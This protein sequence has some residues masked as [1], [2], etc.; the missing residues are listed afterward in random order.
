MKRLLLL[1]LLLASAL[2]ARAA[3]TAAE[4]AVLDRAADFDK[5]IASGQADR[6]RPFLHGRYIYTE[7]LKDA[8]TAQPKLPRTLEDQLAN[9]LLREVTVGLAP[10][11]VTLVDQTA[12]VTGSYQVI[13]RPG[14]DH[15][16]PLAPRLLLRGFFSQT[17]IT[18]APGNTWLLLSEHRSLHDMQTWA[19][20]L[21]KNDTVPSL[22]VASAPTPP[23]ETTHE[24]RERRAQLAAHRGFLPPTFTDLFR[25]Y[26]P[27]SIGYTVDEGDDSFMDFS[28]SAMFPLL[29]PDNYPANLRLHKTAD[30]FS[31]TRY[32]GINLYG[33]ATLRAGQYIGTRPSSP[34][35]G[36]RFN[37]L[38]AARFWALDGRDLASPDNFIE[39]V[40]AHESNGQFLTSKT[41]YDRQEAVYAKQASETPNGSN[42]SFPTNVAGRSTRDNISRGWDYV[43]LNFSRD[44]DTSAPPFLPWIKD[45]VTHIL[46]AKFNYYLPY[47]LMQKGDEQFNHSWEPGPGGHRKRYDGLS[48]RYSVTV[49][50]D[51]APG[52]GRGF[53]RRYS[54]TW[55]TGYYHPAEFNTFKAE[56]S[57]VL[58]NRLPLTLW[59]RYG[60]N[61]DLVDY[62]VKDQSFGLSL[63]YWNF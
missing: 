51:A 38:F 41:L 14:P 58:F 40:Y 2:F 16:T 15:T 26:E 47:G 21:P 24:R 7:P 49:N 22:T 37:P 23:P 34:V 35:V 6:V 33:A 9:R 55:T 36:K 10:L 46:N 63:S 20:A 17:W 8:T 44:W 62:Y 12:I 53:V 42:P 1:C 48:F 3:P 57:F 5:A 18:T 45:D 52:A 29:A 61:R 11:H 32:S 27:T 59:M 30:F 25:S 50:P 31:P 54:L 4:Q 19:S 43:G 39:L 60:Y 28:F 56:W 13:E